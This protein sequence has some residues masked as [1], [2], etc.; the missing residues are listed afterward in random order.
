MKVEL[1]PLR[2][3]AALLLAGSVLLGNPAWARD[4]GDRDRDQGRW[5]DRDRGDRGDR[6]ER[7]GWQQDNGG[8]NSDRERRRQERWQQLP[9]DKRE[10]LMQRYQEYQRLPQQEREEIQQRFERFRQ[11]S[12]DEQ[13]AI[14]QRWRNA[15]P[16]ERRRLRD[17]FMQGR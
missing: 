8:D 4:H 13:D 10:R 12:P 17:Q 9:A 3:L 7:G 6:G 2:L 14:R 11:L 5:S 16:E 1:K 15:P